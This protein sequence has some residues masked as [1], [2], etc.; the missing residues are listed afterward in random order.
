[1]CGDGKIL[2]FY[3]FQKEIVKLV[4]IKFENQIWDIVV[5]RNENL[6]FI[7]YN[8]RIVNVLYEN[9]QMQVVIK[10]MGW[11][12]RSLCCILLNDFFV[13]MESD[14]YKQ[15]KVVC[16]FGVIEK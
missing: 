6:V 8:D 15:I 5:I 14:D 9:E 16:Y 1:M 7:E 10:I 12:F 11:I 13:V 4:E 3:N 2:K